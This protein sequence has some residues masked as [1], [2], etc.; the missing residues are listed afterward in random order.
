[1][2]KGVG[3]IAPGPH[4]AYNLG[5]TRTECSSILICSDTAI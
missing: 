4:G 2:Y 5:M 1:M 3:R